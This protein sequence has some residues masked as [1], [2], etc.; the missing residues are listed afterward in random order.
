MAQ[1]SHSPD[2]DDVFEDDI[3]EV[4]SRANPNPERIGCPPRDILGELARRE[5]PLGDPGY[6]HL[7]KCSP[8]YSEFR[9]LQ[10]SSG[11]TVTTPKGSGES[12]E[13]SPEVVARNAP[14]PAARTAVVT[15]LDL[16]AF[17]VV[18]SGDR[19]DSV[20]HVVTLPRSLVDL[21]LLLPVSSGP[22][23]YEVQVLDANL[24]SLASG[25]GEG[26]IRVDATA[27]RVALDLRSVPHGA[28]Q[29]AVRRQNDEWRLLSARVH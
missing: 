1:D 15:E 3:D 27:V 16:R 9:T 11:K 8:C 17:S 24:Q 25:K 2:G 20:A 7:A 23:S 28:H 21:T 5:R 26:E 14:P 12:I 13:Q 10:S 29:L 18:T 6:E 22:G 4:F 19:T